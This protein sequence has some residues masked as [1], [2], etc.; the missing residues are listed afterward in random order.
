MQYRQEVC[1]NVLQR[2]N[3]RIHGYIMQTKIDKTTYGIESA[4]HKKAFLS[5]FN[6]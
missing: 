2:K 5:H 6:R 4:P 1:K 3:F